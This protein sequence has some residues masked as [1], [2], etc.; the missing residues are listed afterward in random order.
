M[1]DKKPD[2]TALLVFVGHRISSKLQLQIVFATV[3]DPKNEDDYL[4]F[5]KPRGGDRYVIGWT[6]EI[7]TPEPGRYGINDG[8]RVDSPERQPE[9][10]VAKW[11]MLD[12]TARRT[13]DNES[14]RKAASEKQRDAWLK[15]MAPLR[16]EYRHMSAAQKRAMRQLIVEWLSA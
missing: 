2:P 12:A 4:Y 13:R 8:K 9:E 7:R 6:Y 3:S 14:A 5:K 1:S 10:L 16:E 11:S 15:A